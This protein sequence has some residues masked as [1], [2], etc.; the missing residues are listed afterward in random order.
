MARGRREA[1][2][3]RRSWIRWLPVILWRGY[4]LPQKGMLSDIIIIMLRHFMTCACV[5]WA[6]SVGVCVK[7]HGASCGR[8]VIVAVLRWCLY[9]IGTWRIQRIYG[10]SP[11]GEATRNT[12]LIYNTAGYWRGIKP[13]V[14]EVSWYWGWKGVIIWPS[15]YGFYHSCGPNQYT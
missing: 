3:Y 7:W 13:W 5:A 10:F 11:C 6:M 14:C 8:S 12:R 1:C 9:W 4:A 15:V 2:L